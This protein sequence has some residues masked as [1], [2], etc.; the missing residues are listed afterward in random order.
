MTNSDWTVHKFGGSSLANA[1]CFRRVADILDNHAP[2]QLGVVLSACRG[3][4]DMLLGLVV[5][6]ESQDDA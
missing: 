3:V 5:L 1:D 4:T 6:A 2:A